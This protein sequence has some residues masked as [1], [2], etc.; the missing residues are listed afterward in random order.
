M[1]RECLTCLACLLHGNLR[2]V[3]VL[4]DP[5]SCGGIMD[6]V[7]RVLDLAAA[8]IRETTFLGSGCLASRSVLLP[9]R[10]ILMRSDLSDTAAR[11]KA[12]QPWLL[13]QPVLMSRS[14]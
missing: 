6:N 10:R 3:H 13:T 8:S 2:F 7:P 5:E 4:A 11:K 12:C 9:Q 1:S 14:D